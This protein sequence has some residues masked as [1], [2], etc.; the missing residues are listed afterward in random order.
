MKTLLAGAAAICL[1]TTSA[2]AET[3]YDRNIERAAADIVA[4]KMGD[5]RGG[6]AFDQ[7]KI[8]VLLQD[9][10]KTGSVAKPSVT[11]SADPWRNGL[12][13]AIEGKVSRSVF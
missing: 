8:F 10:I 12:A 13:P 4:R 6:F 9:A 3:R 1:L 5:L 11:V 2:F 7:K